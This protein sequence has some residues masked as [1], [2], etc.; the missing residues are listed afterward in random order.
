ME[1]KDHIV[2]FTMCNTC[3]YFELSAT[4]EPCNECLSNPVNENTRVP[5]KYEEKEKSGWEYEEKDNVK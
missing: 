1:Y 3:K 5:L 4:D 2:D